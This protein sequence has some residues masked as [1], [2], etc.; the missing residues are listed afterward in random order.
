M[1]RHTK[2][3]ILGVIE[4]MV[5]YEESDGTR[6]YLFGRGGGERLAERLQ[7]DV[8]VRVPF[9]SPVQAAG[10]SVYDENSLVRELDRWQKMCYI[11]MLNKMEVD[12]DFYIAFL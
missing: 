12:I 1:A 7:T 4:N 2:H 11:R 8:I 10:S 3:D 5:Y 9:S 6:N